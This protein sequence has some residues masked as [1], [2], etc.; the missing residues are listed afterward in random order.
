MKEYIKALH[1]DIFTVPTGCEKS[2]LALDLIEIGSNKH[3]YFFF[4]TCPMLQWNN[5]YYTKSWIRHNDNVW[6]I[7]L[8]NKLYHLI[9]KVSL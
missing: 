9:E 3:F 5:T 8:K 7:E 1:T 2:L 4:N 6:F